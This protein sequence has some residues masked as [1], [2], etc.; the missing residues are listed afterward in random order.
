LMRMPLTIE[1]KSLL[2]FEIRAAFVL[3]FAGAVTR[4]LE[5]SASQRYYKLL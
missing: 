4:V 3:P 5:A 2:R 1:A